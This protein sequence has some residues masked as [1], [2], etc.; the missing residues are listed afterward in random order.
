MAFR[1]QM[2]DKALHWLSE[3]QTLDRHQ[4]GINKRQSYFFLLTVCLETSNPA[5]KIT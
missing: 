3:G 4:Q 5:H 2:Q 1:F